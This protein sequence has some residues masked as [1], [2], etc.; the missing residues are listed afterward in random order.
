M[1]KEKQTRS[2]SILI[3]E[4]MEYYG[5]LGN[6][7]NAIYKYLKDCEKA[8]IDLLNEFDKSGEKIRKQVLF[9]NVFTY[10]ND[11]QALNKDFQNLEQMYEDI[12]N[13][14]NDQE[15]RINEYQYNINCLKKIIKDMKEI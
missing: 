11:Y 6:E 1:N 5:V 4:L 3:T 14:Y 10:K 8:M 13:E 7:Q 9:D 2:I 15:E 12:C